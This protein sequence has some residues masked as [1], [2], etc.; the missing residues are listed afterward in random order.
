MLVSLSAGSH[1]VPV[2]EIIA[3]QEAAEETPKKNAGKWHRVP[4][5]PEE[6]YQPPAFTG[7]PEMPLT[8]GDANLCLPHEGSPRLHRDRW[9]S[10]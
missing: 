2:S 9:G 8:G 10:R 5:S 7:M 1:S 4:R 6:S 3:V